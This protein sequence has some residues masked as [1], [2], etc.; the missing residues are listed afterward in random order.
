MKKDKHDPLKK[1]WDDSPV[2]DI[3]E[4]EWEEVWSGI[5]R[6][7]KVPRTTSTRPGWLQGLSYAAVLIIGIFIGLYGQNMTP[8]DMPE[9]HAPGIN[10]EIPDPKATDPEGTSGG[11]LPVEVKSDEGI[12]FLGLKDVD[13]Q[14]T[15]QTEEGLKE[16]RLTAYTPRGVKIVWDYSDLKPLENN[17]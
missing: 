15:G 16:Y 10:T 3:A 5:H 14:T 2:P 7:L 4:K 8:Q 11:V 6:R 12:A 9:A 17:L 1:L 13:I